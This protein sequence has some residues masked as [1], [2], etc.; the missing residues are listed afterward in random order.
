MTTI[1]VQ[2]AN[3]LRE[4][5]QKMIRCMGVE[6]ALACCMTNQWVGLWQEIQSLNSTKMT[7]H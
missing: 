2:P 3:E 7:R 1:T 4:T 6:Q 5:A